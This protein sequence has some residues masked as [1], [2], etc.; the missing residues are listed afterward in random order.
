MI[1]IE[2]R[3]TKKLPGESSLFINFAYNAEIVEVI[4]QATVKNYNKTNKEWEVPLT[5]LAFLLD[6]L[7]TFGKIK[8]SLLKDRKEEKS[9]DIV[10]SEYKTKPFTYQLNGIKFGL[11]HNRWLLLD[12]PGLGKSL[13]LIY[14]A[15]E[16]KERQ[17]I[18]HCLIIC[19]VNALKQNWVSEILKHSDLS[20]RILGQRKQKNGKIKIGSISDRV[21]DLKSKIEEFFV[22]TNIETL[23]DETIIKQINSEKVNKFD[24]IFV[25]EIH[26]AK[27]QSSKQGHN[28]LKLSA[29]YMIGAT[30]TLLLNSP[31]DAYLPLKWLEL[32]NSTASN[33]KYYYGNFK[34]IHNEIFLGYRNLEVLK[35]QLDK[36]S[37]RRTKDL[38]D[39]P[40]KNII[41]EYLELNDKQELFYK[42]IEQGIIDQVDRVE[43]KPAN[44]LAMITRL[45]Q[46]TACPSIL[47]SEDIPSTKIDRACELAQQLL[48]VGEKVVIFSTFKESLTK[49]KEKLS[50]FQP[51]IC[52]GDT[53]DSDINTSINNFQNEV[54]T[55]L[56]LCTWQ[57]M[58]TG[59]TLT[60]ASYAIFLDV[61]WTAA[62]LEQAQDRIYRIGSKK[63]V[64][65]YHLICKD[66]VDERVQSIV[67][68]KEAISEYVVDDKISEKHIDN[69][70]KYIEE[71]SKLR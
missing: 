67:E 70:K 71:L 2:E 31:F 24:C 53:A 64:F 51:V 9:K 32:D 35:A 12:M 16:L 49:L 47:T 14:L 18:E 5:D 52:S 28:L 44:V 58:G 65:I 6:R 7:C 33:F 26:K 27:N 15:Q 48:E 22:I 60:A 10:L 46:A 45:R 40:P 38:L 3:K 56:M 42:N 13:Q 55:K 29:K 11:S 43:L 21:E 37:L 20:C 8:I 41:N 1:L 63:P 61:P 34:G 50:I 69:L 68:D 62:L 25:D 54:N 19:G 66:T 57:K 23:R 17:G 36:Y 30:G 39:L 59:F 4:K